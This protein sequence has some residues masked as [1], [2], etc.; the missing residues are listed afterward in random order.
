MRMSRRPARS[1]VAMQPRHAIVK[2]GRLTLD[3]PTDLPEGR[4]V[5]LIPLE[6]LLAEAGID[7]GE[8]VPDED[9]PELAF[10]F[11][12]PPHHF[13]EPK[14]IGVEALLDEIRSLE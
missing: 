12:A 1:R 10:R 9:A 13:R 3:E 4:I 7:D 8:D 6:E 11:V 14:K 5:L 2:N